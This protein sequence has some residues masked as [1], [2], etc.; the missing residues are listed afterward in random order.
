[1]TDSGR[2]V[3]GVDGSAASLEAMRTA[4]H[5]AEKLECSLVG[6]TVWEFPQSYP[7]YIIEGWSPEADAHSIAEDAQLQIFGSAA[8]SWYSVVI[9]NGSPS[10]QLIAESE[11]ARM[12]V[13]GSR[14]RGGF[15]GLLLGSVS[16]AC[17]EHGD[18][19]VLVIHGP[20][21][22]GRR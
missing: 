1:M 18:C 13:V 15:T 20:D 5:L 16:R 10:R 8:P 14:G 12:L 9:R 19:P 17:V 3:V 21:R 11:G 7:G 6:V 4:A 2:I 22:A